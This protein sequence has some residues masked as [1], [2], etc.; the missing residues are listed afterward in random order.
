MPATSLDKNFKPGDDSDLSR[1]RV[2]VMGADMCGKTCIIRIL[3]IE[4]DN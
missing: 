1:F 4:I 3:Y 2:L